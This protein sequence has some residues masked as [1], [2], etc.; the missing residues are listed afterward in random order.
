[1]R[2]MILAAAASSMAASALAA[3]P[4]EPDRLQWEVKWDDASCSLTRRR[5][6]EHPM[7][8]HIA[9]WPTSRTMSLRID[10]EGLEGR[11]TKPEIELFFSPDEAPLPLNFHL[12]REESWNH[13][14]AVADMSFLDRLARARSLSFGHP[15]VYPAIDLGDAAK[16]V[17]SLR[18]CREEILR[19]WGVDEAA[20]EALRRQPE[21][22]IPP[23]LRLDLSHKGDTRPWADRRLLSRL[24]LTSEGRVTGCKIVAGSRGSESDAKICDLWLRKAR[25]KPALGADGAP[26]AA[27]ILID[28]IWKIP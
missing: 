9:L 14:I 21:L 11:G 1:M 7:S 28:F 6:G 4:P 27:R 8:F 25:F 20:L 24:D 22:E 17:A 26:A 18:A 2:R 16:A 5:A 10:L 13:L 15:G 3:P 23:S 12:G 19:D